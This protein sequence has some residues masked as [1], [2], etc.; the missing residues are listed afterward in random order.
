VINRRTAHICAALAIACAGALSAT[1][2][3]LV[4]I[5]QSPDE[6]AHFDYAISIVDAHRLVRRADGAS[7]TIVSPQTKYLLRISDF[8]RIAGHSPMHV[9]A[10]YGSAAYFRSLDA[11]A[12]RGGGAALPPGQISYIVRL[13]PF[14]FY[15]LEALVA[16][17]VTSLGG[18]LT[19]TFFAARLL[20]VALTML[21]LFFSYRAC[22][23]LG[24]PPLT[25]VALT[26]AVG[27]F[28]MVSMV[29]SYVQPDNLAFAAVSAALF[30]ATQLRTSQATA[31]RVAPL[32]VALGI[33]AVT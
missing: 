33:L 22:L 2:V 28:P 26:G 3:F 21:A 13:Y 19:A 31:L 11:G 30:F 4:P 5:F 29:S 25:S 9:A 8:A 32:G 23:N 20:C 6:P 17:T 10:D 14:G 18:S 12:P 15:G 24:V 1:W 27:L 16:T 7:A